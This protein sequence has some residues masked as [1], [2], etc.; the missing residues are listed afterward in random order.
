MTVAVK[1]PASIR[2][3]NPGAMGLGAIA[4]RFGAVKAS[5]LSDGESNTIALFPTTEDGAAALF[6]LLASKTYYGKTIAE[7]IA[8]WSG[9]KNPKRRNATMRLNAYLADIEAETE[10]TREDYLDDDILG[11]PETAIPFAKAMAK[12]EA[13]QAYPFSDTQWLAAYEKSKDKSVK[14]AKAAPVPNDLLA[15]LAKAADA[16]MGQKEI[17]GK[18]ANP[19]MLEWYAKAGHPEIKSD[20]VANCAA[21]MCCW[22]E[23]AGCAN[24]K[25]L[26]ARDFLE[27]GA[28]ISEPC[29]N[30]IVVFWREDPRSWKGHVA[31]VVRWDAKTV[32]VRG[33][34]QGNAVNERAFPRSTVLGYRLP[35]PAKRSATEIV[36]NPSV[37][38]K[39]TGGGAALGLFLYNCWN[40]LAGWASAGAQ[41]AG[42]LVGIL[43][44]TANTVTSTVG[45]GKQLAA[46]GGVAWPEV[47]TF[48]ILV[49]AIG[50][51]LYATV[52]RLRTVNPWATE[53][54]AN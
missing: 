24:P 9:A 51:G 38:R 11:H 44:E 22:L 48:L 23:E 25:T 50:G 46:T 18:G 2:H 20:E 4:K 12:H 52:Q 1:L 40:T 41:A 15:A 8:V 47:L 6:A 7:A 14:V 37:Q 35:L 32:W 36:T 39:L 17:P 54:E 26:A 45:A 10:W 31:R 42:E 19:R 3:R 28:K 16:D 49:C 30:C 13:G 34:N 21:A 5:K 53:T 29:E 27:Y 43:P 33:A